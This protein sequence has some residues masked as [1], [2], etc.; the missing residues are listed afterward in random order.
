MQTGVFFLFGFPSF[1]RS[2]RSPKGLALFL[3]STISMPTS[4]CSRLESEGKLKSRKGKAADHV[5]TAWPDNWLRAV[6]NANCS[7]WDHGQPVS[8]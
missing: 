1:L 5:N 3:P 7:R 8:N 6:E 4:F 2:A